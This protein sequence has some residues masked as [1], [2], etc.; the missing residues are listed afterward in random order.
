[1]THPMAV[2][3][4]CDGNRPDFISDETTPAMAALRR[5]GTFHAAHRGIFP[6][7]TRASSASISTG[8]FP[9]SHGLRGNAVAIP[10]E[11]GFEYHDAGKPEF[12]Q[13]F[14]DIYGRMLS[15]PALAE[16]VSDL[17]A[18]VI[19][20]NVSPG[21]AFFHDSYSHAHMFHRH[22]SYAPGR[23]SRPALPAT[24]G[25]DG[26]RVVTDAFI[27]ALMTRRPPV[28]TLWLSEPDVSMHAA[29]LGSDVHLQ[30]LA[31]AD[32]L[33]A[34]V[35]EA[36]ERLRDEGHEVLMM[37][38]SDHGHESVTEVIP[39]ERRLFE[40]GFKRD[41]ES[42]ELMVVPQGS[43]AFIHF[44]AGA[45]DRKAEAI[46]FLR[47]QPWVEEVFLGED[48]PKLGQIPGDDVIAIDMAKTEGRN[49][50]GVPGLSAM[51]TRYSE[52]ED[53]IRTHCGMHGG[54]GHYETRPVLIAVGS[55]FA[56]GATRD[57]ESSITDIA[58][59]VL[60]HLDLPAE[61]MDGRA[62]QATN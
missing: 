5:A 29:P 59:T 10:V 39:V 14:R 13:S 24:P 26:D 6:S 32:S 41:L 58:P 54:R 53:D 11:G 36:V 60:C 16:R 62:L 55:A 57:E 23:Q 44:A 40:A 34:R 7:A 25:H 18:A 4:I 2:I 48:L 47:G 33:V 28:A 31:K 21:A 49:I 27:D 8:C 20:S 43:S 1:M 52:D 50:N 35:A 9:V 19:A 42:P 30:A 37:L 15:R 61:G 51:A 56:A 3:V 22:E 17:G 46:D 12:F 38:G 45:L